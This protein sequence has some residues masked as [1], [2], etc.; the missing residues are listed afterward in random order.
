M[1]FFCF[2][3]SVNLFSAFLPQSRY[4]SFV[5]SLGAGVIGGSSSFCLRC[6]RC[7]KKALV[8][9]GAK[10]TEAVKLKA[11]KQKTLEAA[12][13]AKLPPNQPAATATAAAAAAAAAAA[14][15]SKLKSSENGREKTIEKSKLHAPTSDSRFDDI[16]DR[17]RGGDKDR[18]TRTVDEKSRTTQE[19]DVARQKRKKKWEK[20]TTQDFRTVCCMFLWFLLC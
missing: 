9:S 16:S 5:C 3:F 20:T 17:S 2:V 4:C 10:P 19:A 18:V 7:K 15:A 6:R 12:A 14:V 13:D 8:A 1:S 11:E